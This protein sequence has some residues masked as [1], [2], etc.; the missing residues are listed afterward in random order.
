MKGIEKPYIA[1]FSINGQQYYVYP[2]DAFANNADNKINGHPNNP[3][4]AGQLR[5]KDKKY[6]VIRLLDE[7]KDKQKKDPADILT[8]REIQIITLVADGKPNKQIACHLNISE[9]TVS[10]HLRRIYAKLN[11]DSRAAMI[12]RCSKLIEL[13]KK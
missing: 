3:D 2:K 9:W 4:I 6:V 7:K 8:N 13:L 10:T 12:Y 5:V 1:D 11:V